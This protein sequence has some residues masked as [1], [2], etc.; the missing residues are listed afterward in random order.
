MPQLPLPVQPREGHTWDQYSGK[1]LATRVGH[2][3]ALLSQAY[4][5][6][7][8]D[9]C[10]VLFAPTDAIAYTWPG[11]GK[12]AACH[13]TLR[14]TV[15]V[16]SCSCRRPNGAFPGRPCTARGRT[17]DRRSGDRL[18]RRPFVPVH[19]EE[20]SRRLPAPCDREICAKERSYAAVS[21]TC[22]GL[23]LQFN[24]ARNWHRQGT[25]FKPTRPVC[26]SMLAQ[27]LRQ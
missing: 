19:A 14:R 4:C 5:R 7:M 25:R 23:T 2:T 3:S 9:V 21:T 22:C 1:P 8:L 16:A 6:A 17:Q 10:S 13:G 11:T 15:A 24:F 27:G 18:R 20:M 26:Q 12:T